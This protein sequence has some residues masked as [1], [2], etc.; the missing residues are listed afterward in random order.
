MNLE[1]AGRLGEPGED[2]T[3][4]LLEEWPRVAVPGEDWLRVSVPG[5]DWTRGVLEE[6]LAI[7]LICRRPVH[8]VQQCKSL[9]L[10]INK[11]LNVFE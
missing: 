7:T 6:D 8:M 10:T 2:W 11:L 4:A 1:D 5:E 3:S 9:E